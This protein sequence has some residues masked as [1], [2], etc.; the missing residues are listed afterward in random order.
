MVSSVTT[1]NTPE[2]EQDVQAFF[3]EHPIPQA[4]KTLEQVLERQRVNV[5]LRS[6]E[7]HTAASALGA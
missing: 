5:A 2:L 1:L 6:R 4:T 7:S 3:G